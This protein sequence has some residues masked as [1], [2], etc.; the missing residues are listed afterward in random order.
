MI[1]GLVGGSG[2]VL[3]VLRLAFPSLLAP[4]FEKKPAAG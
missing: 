2:V 3:L 4:A 1:A